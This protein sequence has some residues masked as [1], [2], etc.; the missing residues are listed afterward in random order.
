MKPRLTLLTCLSLVLGNAYALPE[1]IDNSSYPPSAQPA[2]NVNLAATPS[3]N[4]MLE[5][6]AKVEQLQREVQQ[7]TGKLEEQANQIAELK[8]HQSTMYTDVDDRLQRLEGTTAPAAEASAESV[9]SV[10]SETPVET[11]QV[12]EPAAP[13]ADAAP[14]KVNAAPTPPVVAANTSVPTASEAEQ[15]LYQHA[16][17]EL[18]NGH[19]EQ[20]ITEFNAYLAQYP[21]SS[22]AANAQYWLGE[23]FRVKNDDEAAKQA[24]QAVLDKYP[25]HAKA[26]DALLKLGFV[27]LDQNQK[28]LAKQYL[29]RVT[30]DYPDSNAARLASK[31][32]VTIN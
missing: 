16:Y 14:D 4:A 9:G 19:T 22:L 6:T 31:K 21:E 27:A 12:T 15:Q 7:L 20:S 29:T 25:T 1:V 11:P 8:K 2:P 26:P 5:M 28:D 3:T 17:T 24:F 10:M 32:L 18:R 13:A 23:A 30:T